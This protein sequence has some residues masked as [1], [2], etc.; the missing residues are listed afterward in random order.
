M[1]KRCLTHMQELLAD[2]GYHLDD[3]QTFELVPEQDCEKCG[4]GE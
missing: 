3:G 1:I 4:D 2:D